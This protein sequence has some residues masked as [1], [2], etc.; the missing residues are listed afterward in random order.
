MNPVFRKTRGGGYAVLAPV[1]LLDA[2]VDGKALLHVKLR[3]GRVRVGRVRY[4]GASWEDE[5][6]GL[7]LAYGYGFQDAEPARKATRKVTRKATK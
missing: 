3:D 5:T 7:I 6:S 2:C 4:R 1:D